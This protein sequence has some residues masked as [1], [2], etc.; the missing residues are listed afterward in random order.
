MRSL[1]RAHK[2]ISATSALPLGTKLM[3]KLYPLR[4]HFLA[5]DGHTGDVAARSVETSDKS[6]LN[7]IA[8]KGTND[9][10]RGSRCL[11]CLSRR[12]TANSSDHRNLARHQMIRA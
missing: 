3:G 11:C 10:Y 5:Y 8:T 4:P 12:F 6:G 7:C 2:L 9:W 1:A